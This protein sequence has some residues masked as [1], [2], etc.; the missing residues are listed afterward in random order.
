[1]PGAEH[2]HDRDA[3][4]DGRERE[5]R[6]VEAHDHRVDAA[7]EVAGRQAGRDADGGAEGDRDDADQ[8]RGATA[9]D[10]ARQEVAAEVVGAED[11]ALAGR[12]QLGARGVARAGRRG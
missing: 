12:Q 11:E 3:E 4:Q 5:Q 7:A 1:M 9:E 6:I 10:D 8:E 2:R